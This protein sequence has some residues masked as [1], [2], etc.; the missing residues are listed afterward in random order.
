MKE[1]LIEIILVYQILK[2]RKLNLRNTYF[3]FTVAPEVTY[4]IGQSFAEQ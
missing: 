3:R 2:S 4:F 1:I